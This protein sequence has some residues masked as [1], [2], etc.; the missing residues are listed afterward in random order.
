MSGISSSSGGTFS[1]SLRVGVVSPAAEESSMSD[2]TSLV[3]RSATGSITAEVSEIASMAR[4]SN[5]ARKWN[6]A[7]FV[8]L[9]RCSSTVTAIL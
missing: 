4:R 7:W 1:A 2:S 9:S 5:N 8:V 6:A 3:E